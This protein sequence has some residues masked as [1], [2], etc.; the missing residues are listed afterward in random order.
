MKLRYVIIASVPNEKVG[1][2]T[3]NACKSKIECHGHERLLLRTV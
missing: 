1:T 3:I 2:L